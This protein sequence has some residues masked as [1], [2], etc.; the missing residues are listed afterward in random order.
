[1][2][3]SWR[4]IRYLGVS[5]MS[6][7][8][9]CEKNIPYILHCVPPYK[10]LR[11]IEMHYIFTIVV[12]SGRVEVVSEDCWVVVGAWVEELVSALSWARVASEVVT[13]GRHQGGMAWA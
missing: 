5:P 11:H 6:H 3:R 13:R 9:A 1:M 4:L 10:A 12:K 8:K 7:M 2:P